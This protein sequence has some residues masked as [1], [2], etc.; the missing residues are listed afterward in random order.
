MNDNMNR[1]QYERELAERQRR[2]LESI[3][4]GAQPWRPCL[5]D[6]CPQCNGTGVSIL[7]PCVHMISCPCPKCS[8]CYM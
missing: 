8:P 6:N 3:N 5:H 2:H 1:E 7:G 4:Y